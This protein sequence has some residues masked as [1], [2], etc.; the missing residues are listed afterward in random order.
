MSFL[1]KFK[2]IISPSEY[3]DEMYE[4]ENEFEE[5]EEDEEPQMAHQHTD[6]AR[7]AV[8]APRNVSYNSSLELKVVRPEGF[9]NV[10]AIA[11]HLLSKR[12]VVLNL[13]DTNKE[14][15]RRMLDFLSGVA[16]AI[17]GNL[18]KVSNCTF[19][20]TPNNVNISGE[21]LQDMAEDTEEKSGQLF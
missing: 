18:K 13:E 20:I 4:D 1:S 16:Y 8:A 10:T 12:T 2:E 5:E 21:Q 11:D 6:S 7:P 17:G 19:I 15:A 3:S 9:E 14:A